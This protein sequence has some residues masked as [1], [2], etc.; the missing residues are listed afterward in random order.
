MN[1][2]EETPCETAL[3]CCQCWQGCNTLQKKKEKKKPWQL[4]Y[5]YL[6]YFEATENII[7]DWP[8]LSQKKINY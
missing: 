2:D 4:I 7:Q 3:K 5:W 8:V 1:I 6:L